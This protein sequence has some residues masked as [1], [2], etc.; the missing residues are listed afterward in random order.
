[1]MRARF[2]PFFDRA[3]S[4]PKPDPAVLRFHRSLGGYQPTS[5]RALSGL[6][7]ELGLANV[8]VKDES[9]R[10]G[11][12]SFKA[13][14]ATWAVHRF[15]ERAGP[16]QFTLASATDGNHGRALAWAA[17]QANQRA[18]IYV[19]HHTVAARIEAIRREGAEV[20]VVDGTFDDAVLRADK[21]NRVKGRQ[22]ISD[23]A[24][25]GYMEI[26]EWVIEGYSTIFHEIEVEI[27]RP[28]DVVIVQAGVGGLAAAA[29]RHFFQAGRQYR[30]ALV[31]VQAV[32]ADG[33]VESASSSD[34]EAHASRGSLQTIMSGLSCA[35]PSLVAWPILRSGVTLFLSVEDRFA[36]EAMRRLYF[37]VDVVP[38][39]VAG[40]AGAAG[41]AGLLALM[42]EPVFGAAK[43]K[44]G[45][46][47]K[48]SVLVINS[49]G[50]TDP[51]NFRRIIEGRS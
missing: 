3:A 31:C 48:T 38:R 16:G 23:T 19:P 35:M 20:I 39:V 15:L 49:E 1:M 9:R 17:R 8:L 18:V 44:L 40:E 4:F 7:R 32:E 46:S 42:R 51:A 2:N 30:P 34:G 45:L 36:E 22:V 25:P 12:N 11:L 47:E 33:L 37:P 13:V 27:D 14:G 21:E 29:V 28:P 6:A 41:L 10:F 43:E 5:L 50:D 24:Y 26:P